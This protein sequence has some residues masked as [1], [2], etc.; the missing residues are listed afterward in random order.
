[1]WVGGGL[2]NKSP[3]DSLGK[4]I[5]VQFARMKH[6]VQETI[7]Q[8]GKVVMEHYGQA[9][10]TG[11]K[12]TIVAIVTEA[13]TA[14][15]KLIC[16]AIKTFYPEHGIVAEESGAYQEA[17]E[18]IWYI[19]PLDG[20]KNFASGV[21]LFGINMALAKQG[22]IILA[23]IYLPATNELVIA[24]KSKGAFITIGGKGRRLVCSEKANWEGAYGIGPIRYS[25]QNMKLQ[26]QISRL[27][28]ETAWVNAIASPAVSAVWMADGRRDW[29]TSSG[30]NSWDFA[31][32][33]L[34]AR[35]AGCVVTNFEGKEWVPGD[36][37]II[38]TNK[39]LHPDLVDAVREAYNIQS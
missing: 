8:A 20:T 27:S 2:D 37:G 4:A 30:K 21:S 18:Y 29:Y 35:E 19:D 3:N 32:P 28:K 10:I 39:H 34:V 25:P 26:E 38:I 16:D 33:W 36:K 23:A 17:A 15:D 5:A 12:E 9:K 24:E 22:E 14:A 7:L 1:M 11:S 31:A 13:D 6:F